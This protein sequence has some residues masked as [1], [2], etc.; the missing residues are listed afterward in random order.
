[1][2]LSWAR[3]NDP[4]APKRGRTAPPGVRRSHHRWPVTSWAF[5]TWVRPAFPNGKGPPPGIHGGPSSRAAADSGVQWAARV[6]RPSHSGG[7][8][9]GKGAEGHHPFSVVV[10]RPR[11]TVTAFESSSRLAAAET[12]R[13]HRGGERTLRRW[14]PSP[15]ASAEARTWRPR[16]GSP[17]PA[18]TPPAVSPVFVHSECVRWPACVRYTDR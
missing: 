11:S 9:R 8:E 2:R 13:D 5:S 7:R 17:P 14:V 12:A 3:C 10:Y 4:C 15:R 6:R 18:S 1:M 16:P